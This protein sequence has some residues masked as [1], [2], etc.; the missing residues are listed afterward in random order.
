M[1]A[2]PDIRRALDWLS[3]NTHPVGDLAEAEI[4]RRVLDALAK[5][6]EGK[7]AA[8]STIQRRRGVIVNA[9]GQAVERKLLLSNP[10]LSLAS[11]VIVYDHTIDRQRSVT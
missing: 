8:D 5:T 7:P 2:P 11:V 1:T 9:L 6:H 4:T 3:H 10:A